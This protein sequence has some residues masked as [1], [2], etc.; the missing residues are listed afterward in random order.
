MWK[1][2]PKVFAKKAKGAIHILDRFHIMAHMSKAIDE[3]RAKEARELQAKGGIPVLADT[4]RVFLKRVE[5]LTEKQISKLADLLKQNLKTVNSYLLKQEFQ[6][7][8]LCKSPYWAEMFLDKWVHQNHVPESRSIL[9]IPPCAR[10][11]ECTLS[12]ELH[13]V[14]QP[15][16]QDARIAVRQ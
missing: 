8:W 13:P 15:R 3:V 9:P 2:Y 16:R 1:P 6:L 11:T 5:N 4:R 7:F 14:P 12:Q 10:P